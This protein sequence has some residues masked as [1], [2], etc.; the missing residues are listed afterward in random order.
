MRFLGIAVVAL[1]GL[2][3][4]DAPASRAQTQDYPWCIVYSGTEGDGGTH[5]MFTSYHQCL[6]TATP[7]SGGVCVRNL[8][9]RP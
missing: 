1:A 8:R 3:A 7:G 4:L 2:A 5:C 6:M 9:I